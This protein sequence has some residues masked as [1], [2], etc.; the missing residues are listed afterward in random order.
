MSEETRRVLKITQR[1][2][3]KPPNGKVFANSGIRWHRP[4]L[5]VARRFVIPSSWICG[6]AGTWQ[7]RRGLWLKD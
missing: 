4:M 6:E 5:L 2:F 3:V 7:R 1:V